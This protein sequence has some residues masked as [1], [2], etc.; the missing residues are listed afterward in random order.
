MKIKDTHLLKVTNLEENETT[1]DEMMCF[2]RDNQDFEK[3]FLP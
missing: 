1:K 2:L 3:K